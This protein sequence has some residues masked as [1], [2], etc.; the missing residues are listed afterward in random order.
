[1]NGLENSMSR[2]GKCHNSAVA[3]SF[4]ELLKRERMK[5]KVYSTQGDVRSDV[6]DYI[7][8]FYNNKGSKTLQEGELRL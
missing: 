8:N 5:R 3:K 7:G 1:V 6:S 2:R 4:F